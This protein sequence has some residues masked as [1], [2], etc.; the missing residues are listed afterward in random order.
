MAQSVI[1]VKRRV[2]MGKSGSKAIRNEGNIPAVI[3]G[4]GSES[5]SIVVNPTELK[6][7]LST[8][9]GENTLLEMHIKDG[10]KE[11]KK[12]SLLRE[13]QMDYITN[14]SIHLDFMELDMNKSFSLKVPV[15]IVGRPIGVHEE[16]GLLEEILREIEIECLPSDI[17]N[18]FEVEVSELHINDSIHVRDIEVSDKINVLDDPSSTVVTIL[19]PRVEKVVVEEGEEE[20]EE[21][22]EEEAAETTEEKKEES[23]ES[24]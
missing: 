16:K 18:V 1:N 13:V 9:A 4:K 22:T 14:K 12:L 15:K 7:A 10:D 5:I 2:R 24:E 21:V 17:P 6:E 8:D 19:T 20:I 11:I 3:Y 23:A